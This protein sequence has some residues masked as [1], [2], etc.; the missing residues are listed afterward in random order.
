LEPIG[1]VWYYR[2][3]V[4]PDAHHAFGKK[5]VR[6][7]LG[8]SSQTEAKRLEKIEDVKFE[9]TLRV[10]RQTGP[11]GLPRGSQER[12]EAL[13][14]RVM[15]KFVDENADEEDFHRAVDEVVP[16]SDHAAVHRAL[17]AMGDD[18]EEGDASLDR[19][20]HEELK[21]FL[22]KCWALDMGTDRHWLGEIADVVRRYIIDSDVEHTIDWAYDQW[23][24]ARAR[25]QQTHDEADRYLTAFK[26]SA[27][28]R[29]LS[30]VRRRHVLDWRDELK[31]NGS[32]APKSINHRLE[33][34]SAIL[35]VGWQDAEMQPPDLSRI[36]VP[37]PV[38]SGR[39]SWSRDELLKVLGALEPHSWAAW[40]FVLLLTTG[41][42]IG[43]L[44]AAR[45]EWYDPIGCIHTP[46]EFTKMKKP[47]LMPVI[48]LVRAPLVQHLSRVPA[49]EY[50][51]DAPRPSKA[52]LKVS[53]EASKWFGRFFDRK[54]VEIDKVVHELRH[55]WIQAARYSPIKKEV[56]EIITGHSPKTVSDRYGGEKPNELMSANEEICGKFLDAEMTQAIWRLV[57]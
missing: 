31:R 10:A 27:R 57:G 28:V 23:V 55:T 16:E 26:T 36:A 33:I 42:R 5:V 29:L 19:L 21:P 35:R 8:T 32:L 17:Y 9:A 56:Y 48:E 43:E 38:S 7:S 34:V 1:D 40:V 41:T 20:W 54:G 2:R 24:K 52:T 14:D 11:D 30:A 22:E 51:F 25:P 6:K 18:W 44:I 53:H 37:E 47:H 50:M 46:A 39:T 15:F 45:R 49:G 3:V 13:V 12:L 4:P